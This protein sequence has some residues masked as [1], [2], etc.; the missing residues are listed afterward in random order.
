MPANCRGF[1]A[2]DGLQHLMNNHAYN[3]AMA[4]DSILTFGHAKSG[5]S[6][7]T[8]RSLR[9]PCI[10]DMML[11][12][13]PMPP[14]W[15]INFRDGTS[16]EVFGQTR[17][18]AKKT[19]YRQSKK[20]RSFDAFCLEIRKLS[21]S[22]P[23]VVINEASGFPKREIDPELNSHVEKVREIMNKEHY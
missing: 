4:Q 8:S 20:D 14:L 7:F 5:K 6:H 17:R 2:M 18:D 12:M 16:V 19:A 13:M 22:K 1:E 11:S 21:L 23:M 15:K 9:T 3:S 10:M